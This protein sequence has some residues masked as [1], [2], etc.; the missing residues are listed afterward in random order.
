[1]L[2]YGGH[3]NSM[4]VDQDIIS[5]LIDSSKELVAEKNVDRL[6]ERV[7]MAAQRLA[8]ADGATMYLATEDKRLNISILVNASLGIH[9]GGTSG[10]VPRIQPIQMYDV[11]T[12]QA[13]NQIISVHAAVSKQTI[14]ID[15]IYNDSFDVST[16]RQFDQ[17]NNYQTKSVLAI[18]LVSRQ[19]RTLAVIQLINSTG[20][21]GESDSFDPQIV[22][23]IEMLAVQTTL[24]LENL[25]LISSEKHV[26]ESFIAIIA[27]AIDAKSPYT[28]AHCKRVPVLVRMIASAACMQT[29]GPFE[30]YDLTEDDWYALHLASWLHDCGKITTPEYVMDKATKL[31]TVYNRIHEIRT[32]FEVLRRDAHISYLKKRLKGEPQEQLLAEFNAQ[33]KQLESDY[34][35]VAECNVG[36]RALDE[37]KKTELKRIASTYTWVRN[38]DKYIGL[39]WEELSRLGGTKSQELPVREGILEDTS[40]NYFDGINR[41]ELHNLMIE[42]GTLNTDE[43]L[44]VNNHVKV[45]AE[46]LE[47]IP[48]PPNL[49]G[50]VEYA[51]NHHE[52]MDGKG[53]PNGLTGAEMSVPARMMAV[54]DIFEAL[55]ATD[56]PYKKIKKLSECIDIMAGMAKDGHIDPDIFRLFVGQGLYKE[57][58]GLYMR[59]DQIDDVDPT[60]YVPLELIALPDDIQEAMGAAAMT[61]APVA[62]N[63]SAAAAGAAPSAEAPPAPAPRMAPPPPDPSEKYAQS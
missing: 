6:L 16:I 45:T 40:D 41:S 22:S 10:S 39:S 46:M 49:S 53:Y 59:P 13:N 5:D 36:D 26:M 4:R 3:Y 52:R 58:A 31:E 1:M 14:K 43:M 29:T 15:D 28:S 35:M 57:Y 9:L 24:A 44:K 42:R 21:S 7:L 34:A 33:V 30:F 19:G 48:F 51:A 25:K 54:A 11:E 20:V 32:R 12:G 56:R 62:D 17:E 23:L 27:Q 61:G 18:P 8:M 2:T 38:F 60:K 37:K 50:V 47:T 63:L 55:T